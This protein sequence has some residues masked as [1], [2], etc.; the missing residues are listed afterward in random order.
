[1][2][3]PLR[4]L[5]PSHNDRELKRML[6][7]VER[8]NALERELTLLS[9][10]DLRGRTG[11]LKQRLENGEPLDDVMPEAFALVREATKRTLG[12]RHYDVQLIGGIVLHRGTG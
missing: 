4:R 11:P 1:M 5:I 9:D 8:I 6:P 3:N 10:A 7:G 12:Q 2:Q